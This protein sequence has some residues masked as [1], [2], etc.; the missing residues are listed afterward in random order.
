[1]F[2]EANQNNYKITYC[3]YFSESRVVSDLLVQ[4]DIESARQVN[5]PKYLLSADHTK[6]RILTLN[7]NNNIAKFDNLDLRK[8]CVE[9]NGQRYP[10]DRISINYS[11]ADYLDQ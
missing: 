6:H 8:Y 7:K 5:S 1:M 11:E 10:R 3:E 9:I 2:N 4:H